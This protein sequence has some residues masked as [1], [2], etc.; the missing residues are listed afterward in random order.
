M[1]PSSRCQAAHTGLRARE[2]AL[3]APVTP[4]AHTNII[5]E[6]HTAPFPR[7]QAAHKGLR[8]REKA[9]LTA[10]TLTADLEARN[11]AISDLEAAGAK[12]L[13]G[14]T[15]KAKKVRCKRYDI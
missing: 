12:V 7:C 6:S 14:D 9:L 5:G 11:R 1:S 13:G 8:A 4:Q 2:K 3:L 15:A 10:D